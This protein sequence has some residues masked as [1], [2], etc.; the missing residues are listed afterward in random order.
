[1]KP[2]E[3]FLKYIEGSRDCDAALLNA[4][5]KKGMLRAKDDTFDYRKLVGLAAACVATVFLCFAAN[6]EPVK[7][8]A[9]DFIHDGS[10]MTELGS[11]TLFE[12]LNDMVNSIKDYLG[13]T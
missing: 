7:S 12:Y 4:A 8:A 6:T 11:V 10:S 2:S 13:G 1:M 9:S 5:V 3:L